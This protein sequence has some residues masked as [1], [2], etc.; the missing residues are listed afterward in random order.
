MISFKA[1]VLDDD[2][3]VL[4]MLS[5]ILRRRNYTVETYLDPVNSPLFSCKMHD[6]QCPDLI[7]SDFCMPR[8]NGMEVLEFQMKKGCRCR[9]LALISGKPPSETALI[10]LAKY[11]TR[12]FPK[13]LP[14]DDFFTW[15]GHVEHEVSMLR[16]TTSP[17]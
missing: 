2:F 16:S 8:M 1:V 10:R 5:T 3:S 17:A 12:F 9:H 7:I 13:P 4:T 14:L 11:G 6:S 15:L